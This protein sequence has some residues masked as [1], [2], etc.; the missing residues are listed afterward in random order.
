[1][2]IVDIDFEGI[3]SGKLDEFIF[4]GVKVYV[5]IESPRSEDVVSWGLSRGYI[6]R[7]ELL[8][9]FE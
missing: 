2:K 4:L 6:D 1:M 9:V 5:A 8:D 3:F 7:D